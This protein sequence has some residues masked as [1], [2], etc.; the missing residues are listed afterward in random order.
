MK[1]IVLILFV[2]LASCSAKKITENENT[3][4]KSSDISTYNLTIDES[5]EE[6][7]YI[8]INIDGLFNVYIIKNL[9]EDMYFEVLVNEKDIINDDNIYLKKIRWI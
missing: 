2:I 5:L 6:N 7:E 3:L 8:P 1:K 9:P 4:D